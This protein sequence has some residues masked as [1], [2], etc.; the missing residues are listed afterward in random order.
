MSRSILSEIE[1]SSDDTETTE[2]I[3]IIYD[4]P[5]PL[6]SSSNHDSSEDGNESRV[7]DTAY[8]Y[9]PVWRPDTS[10]SSSSS[11]EDDVSPSEGDKQNYEDTENLIHT[12]HWV[13]RPNREIL[14]FQYKDIGLGLG[15]IKILRQGRAGKRWTTRIPPRLLKRLRIMALLALDTARDLDITEGLDPDSP[16]LS[17]EE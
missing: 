5:V 2:N 7:S 8:E 15:Q 12:G 17:G 3:R 6:T 14:G 1:M 13:T 4:P 10:G 16:A 11:T 9:D